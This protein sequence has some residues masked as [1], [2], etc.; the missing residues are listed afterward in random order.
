MDVE[1][2]ATNFG[3]EAGVK[4]YIQ[5]RMQMSLDR[6]EGRLGRVEVTLTNLH[7]RNHMKELQCRVLAWISRAQ[8]VIIAQ[9]DEDMITAVDLAAERTKRTVRRQI[10][11]RRDARREQRQRAA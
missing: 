10:N 3:L 1:V 9:T 11:R 7:G 8:N 4:D 2:R 6:F 5:R